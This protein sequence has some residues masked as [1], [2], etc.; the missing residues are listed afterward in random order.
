[1]VGL[2]AI[3]GVPAAIGTQISP[4]FFALQHRLFDTCPKFVKLCK[5]LVSYPGNSMANNIF[6]PLIVWLT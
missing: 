1:M 3:L 4:I 5:D 6:F 2:R